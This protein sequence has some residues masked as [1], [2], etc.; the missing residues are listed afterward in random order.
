MAKNDKKTAG[1]MVKTEQS[2]V[3]QQMGT[4]ATD[5]NNE[6]NDALQR[7]NQTWNTA[8]GGYTNLANTGGLNQDVIGNIRG[9]YSSNRPSNSGGGSGA[10]E[11]PPPVKTGQD[12]FDDPYNIFST[13]GK[14]GGI[15]ESRMRAGEPTLRNLSETGG[16]DTAR[17]NQINS[18]IGGLESMGKTGGMSPEDMAG[19]RGTGF[20]KF[21]DTG[22]WSDA[23][24]LNF[25]SRVAAPLR[26][27]AAK[28][29]ED[30]ARSR[31]LTGGYSPNLA[32]S[33]AKAARQ[34]AFGTGEAISNSEL[35]LGDKIREGQKWG[36]TGL[37]D[38]EE[39]LQSLRT[40]NMLEGLG[41]AG[42]LGLN[43]Q[44]AI[45]TSR[46]GGANGLNNMEQGIQSLISQNKLAGAGG[47][48]DITGKKLALEEAA[49]GR[50]A[51]EGAAAAARDLAERQ[52]TAMN[53]RWIGENLLGG[54]QSGLAGIA[55]MYGA[56]PGE[57][58]MYNRDLLNIMGQQTGANQGLI[59]AQ[60]NVA[61][62]PSAW[63]KAIG[64]IGNLASAAGGVMGGLSGLPGIGRKVPKPQAPADPYIYE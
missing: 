51:S 58:S 53:E 30:M 45:N 60:T 4:T 23:D 5:W 16:F 6:R 21:A 59:N 3:N 49:R 18:A 32:A 43:T 62:L 20:Q 56:T 25:R 38:T 10:P 61:A 33:M 13:F 35:D 40:K 54:T 41:A 17:M 34:S 28:I 29:Q 55:N 46:L 15:D 37:R 22:G 1:N 57:T 39:K 19:F 26:S 9:L 31:A 12:S 64:G 63:D 52:F 48:T 44:S 50:A 7:Q 8:V 36:I 2:R 42:N 47:M 27:N 24:K 11:A 14:T